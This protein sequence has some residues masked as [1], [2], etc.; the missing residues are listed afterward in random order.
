MLSGCGANFGL[1]ES[2]TEQGAEITKQWRLFTQMAAAI[3]AL[4]WGLILWSVIRYRRRSDEL[5][6]QTLFNLPFEVA[7]TTLPLVIVAFLFISS[8]RA[9]ERVNSR[10]EDPDLTVEVTGFQ[11]QWRFTYPE[12]RVDVIGENN[13]P[14]EMVVPEGSTVRIIL[15]STDVIH[16]FWLPEFMVKKDAIPG[17]INEFDMT[18][19]RAGTFESGRCVEYCGLNHDDMRF[20]VR[21]VPQAEFDAWAAGA[22]QSRSR[23]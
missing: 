16:A 14:A 1:P 22:A 2:A 4:V 23:T 11:W 19:T 8:M 5:P 17:R 18:V 9:T 6:K 15:T 3:G 10:V 7:Y 12:Q 13:R 20:T 21:A